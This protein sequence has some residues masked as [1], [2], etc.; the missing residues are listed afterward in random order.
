MKRIVVPNEQ[1]FFIPDV[2]PSENQWLGWAKRHWGV[3]KKERD[4]HK[5]RVVCAIREA[6]ITEL[7][8]FPVRIIFRWM[9][10]NGRRDLDN[11]AA[12]GRKIIID[13]IVGEGLLPD[14]TRKYVC[15][16]EDTF[17]P[18]DKKKAGVHVTI[19]SNAFPT[20]AYPG[21]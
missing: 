2:F 5:A 6:G 8:S 20:D 12:G 15:G 19:Y 4:Y 18:P 21:R 1:W 7:A 11:I 3:Y 16:F 9:E 10:K 13:A 14:D 17:P